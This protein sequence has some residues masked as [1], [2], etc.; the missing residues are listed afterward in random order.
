[1][2]CV[3][4]ST[5]FRETYQLLCSFRLVENHSIVELLP[6]AN[7]QTLNIQ[8]DVSDNANEV[9]D[10]MRVITNLLPMLLLR[11]SHLLKS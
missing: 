5:V 6:L 8:H 1:M 4:F 11:K 2:S 7:H 10:V 3:F 9:H